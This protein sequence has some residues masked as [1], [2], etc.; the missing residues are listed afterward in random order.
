MG[1]CFRTK[2]ITR[3]AVSHPLP[4]KAINSFRGCCHERSFYMK[5]KTRQLAFDAILAAMVAVLGFIALDFISIKVTFE[6]VPIFIGALMF[7]PMDGLAVGFVG[8]LIYQL[9]RY[10]V[11]VTTALWILP[12]A[13]CGLL[14]G[15]FAKKKKFCFGIKDML[16]VVIALELLITVMNTFVMYVDSKIYGYWFKGFIAGSLALR[17]L[18][19]V[20]KA[21][22]Y[23]FVME[24]LLKAIRKNIRFETAADELRK[25]LRR[26]KITARNALAPEERT[27]LSRKTAERVVASEEFA[28]AETIMVYRAVRTELDPEPIAEAARSLGKKVAY[29]LCLE[30]SEMAA[31]VPENDDAWQKGYKDIP[32]PVPEKSLELQPEDID[33]MVCPCSAFDEKCGRMGMGGG[34]YDRYIPKCINAAVVAVAFECQKADE[35]PMESWDRKM[36]AVFTSSAVYR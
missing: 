27:V 33:L 16:I 22:A 13:L 21:V 7:G 30:N 35:I 8:T 11:S 20:V 14:A 12:Y 34:Y 31:M 29:P 1:S 36:D 19:C 4:P 28:K 25:K 32:E 23:S 6:S 5:R 26:E 2:G 15:L 24:P 3:G 18:I 17:L 10:G 9:L